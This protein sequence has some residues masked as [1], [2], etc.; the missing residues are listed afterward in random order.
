[1]AQDKENPLARWSRLKREAAAG[2][3]A[4]EPKPAPGE[5]ARPAETPMPV[6]PPLETLTPDSDFSPFM[7]KR[8]DDRL[9]RL[10]LKKLFSDPS[11]NIVDGLDD[12]AEDFNL[13]EDLP[14]EM[15]AKLEHARNV[16]RGPDPEPDPEP[17]PEAEP[18]QDVQAQDGLPDDAQILQEKNEEGNDGEDQNDVTRRQDA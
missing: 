4:P 11:L 13:L 6:L 18:E 8:V 9:R 15:V 3:A 2:T 17:E 5:A 16:L 1:M 12:F 10:A 7:D 14:P